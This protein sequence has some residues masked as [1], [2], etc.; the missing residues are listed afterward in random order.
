[1]SCNFIKKGLFCRYL[2][3]HK[4]IL[5]FISAVILIACLS[6]TSFA[7]SPVHGSKSA[8]M[9][10]S[11]V[12]LSDDPSAMSSNPAGLTQL[13]GTIFYG[14]TTLIIPS[15]TFRNPSGNEEDSEFQVFFPPHFY[16]V[17]DMGL[18]DFRFGLGIYSPFGIGG[19]KWDK[20]G[21]TRYLSVQSQVATLAANPT[22]TYQVSPS[23]SVGLG[24]DYMFSRNEAK[25]MI[26]QSALA[27][28]DSTAILKAD[29]GGWG[30]NAGLL[31]SPDERLRFGLAYRS[32]I[33]V[34][35]TG[36][37]ELKRLAPAVQPL[38]GGSDFTTKVRIPRT[39]PDI[40]TLGAA[41]SPSKKITLSLECEQVKWSSFR[42]TRIDLGREIPQA[43]LTD[44]VIP[45][46]WKD[47]WLLKA[48][49]EYKLDNRISLRGG[50]TYFESPVPEAT[51]EPGMPDSRQHYI[52]LGFG[53]IKDR[54]VID[55]FYMK[56]FYENRKV[57][58][59][60][61][62]GRYSN[63]AHYS[64]ISIGYRF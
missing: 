25:K 61:L 11:F 27:A 64:G 53:Y 38:F 16:I 12:A 41:W 1:M 22:I 47:I 24:L 56:G 3:V 20:Q 62:S 30:F 28:G 36:E 60:I 48:G 13:Q 34:E 50:Y 54:I 57:N 43:G 42:E 35:H 6:G 63:D 40:I 19:R 39:F 58:N 18:R 23:L 8:A 31:V 21:L 10:T 37:M 17:S 32:R 44:S 55:F 52:C 29:G 9:G 59:S 51:L 14:G 45:M 46:R 15:T 2:A 5:V 7:N 4:G 26:N 33:K 49:A